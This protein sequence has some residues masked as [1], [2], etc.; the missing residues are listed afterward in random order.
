MDLDDVRVFTKVVDLGSFTKAAR[1][2]GLPKSTVSRRVS[3]LEEHLGTRLLQRTT[4]KLHLTHAG[5]IYFASTSRLIEELAEAERT[6]LGLEEQPRG[7]LRVT[8]PG[9]L[10][11]TLSELLVDFQRAYPQVDL[12]VFATGRRVDL[13]A[14][15]YDLALRAGRVLESGLVQR[16][17]YRSH[18]ALFASPHYLQNHPELRHPRDLVD[19]RC[20]I[21][22][23]EQVHA[24]WE[25]FGPDG[26]I[27]V[28]VRGSLATRDVSLLRRASAAGMGVAFIPELVGQ[29]YAIDG[30][31]VHVLPDYRSQESNLYA[32][33]PSPRHLSS[34]VR[35]FIDFLTEWMSKKQL[36]V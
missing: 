3:E 9:D 27:E 4:R 5:Q 21:F 26:R 8:T 1:A 17:L 31:L 15:G 36:L 13:I 6:V 10:S 22:S 23:D 30:R 24:T 20:V 7:L 28:P 11:G 25:L 34:K 19:H 18:F 2:L 32:V 35:V 29:A 16:L 14:E 33:Y 12:V